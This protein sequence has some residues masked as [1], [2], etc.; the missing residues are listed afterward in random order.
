MISTSPMRTSDLNPA[1]VLDSAI[2]IKTLK[3]AVA[4]DLNTVEDGRPVKRIG[5]AF[6]VETGQQFGDA[7]V[8]Y[9]ITG[10]RAQTAFIIQMLKLKRL[11]IIK[12]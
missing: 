5:L 8:K 11:Y 10:G 4:D 2:R 3:R 9:H 6:W 1:G 12:P 7:L